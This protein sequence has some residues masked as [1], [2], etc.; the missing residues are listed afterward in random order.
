[1]EKSEFRKCP[2]CSRTTA[3]SLYFDEFPCTHCDGTVRVD[4]CTCPDC[5]YSY[6]LCNGEFLDGSLISEED[7]DQITQ[8]LEEALLEGSLAWSTDEQPVLAD[9]LVNCIRCASPRTY[10]DNEGAY[11]CSDCDFSW[12]MVG[13]E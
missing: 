10:V 3:M 4:Y 6:R 1:M 13:Y 12:E 7:L 8:E 9:Q 2:H 5:H 11:C